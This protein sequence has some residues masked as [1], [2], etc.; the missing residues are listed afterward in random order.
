MGIHVDMHLLVL[1]LCNSDHSSSLILRYPKN[2][3]INNNDLIGTGTNDITSPMQKI[4]YTDI[5]ND[6]MPLRPNCRS[7]DHFKTDYRQPTDSRA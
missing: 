4:L 6:V 2:Y 3:L 5:E 1:F 7:K